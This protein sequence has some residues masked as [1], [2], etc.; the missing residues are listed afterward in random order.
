[1]KSKTINT[2]IWAAALLLMS[3]VAQAHPGHAG[4]GGLSAGFGHPFSGIDHMLAMIAVGMLAAQIGARAIWLLPMSFI[5][6]MIG[7][8]ALNFAHLPI[9]FVEQGIAASVLILGLLIA[10]AGRFPLVASS[11]IVGLFAVFHGYAHAA[12]M[13]S[14]L[15]TANYAI[16]FVGA[17][18]ILHAVGIGIGIA[19]R[20]GAS[21]QL[22][23]VGG[24]AIATCGLLLMLGV[25]TA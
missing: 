17:T 6:L 4:H 13:H 11:S 15:A 14:G 10:S 19:A 20:R 12:E 2:G 23:R 18:A 3:G 8:A 7:G 24:A 25:V 1:M 5:G 16:G 22:V 21:R 9:P